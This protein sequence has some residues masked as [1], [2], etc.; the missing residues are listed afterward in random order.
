MAEYRVKRTFGDHRRGT[1]V[2][3]SQKDAQTLLA[4]GYVAEIKPD[5]KPAKK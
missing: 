2:E 1:K 5:E 4:A 3:L